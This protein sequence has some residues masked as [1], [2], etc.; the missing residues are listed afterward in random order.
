MRRLLRSGPVAAFEL[1]RWLI[2]WPAAIFALLVIGPAARA[3]LEANELEVA[4]LQP[5]SS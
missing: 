1:K 2:P 3:P 4:D 5:S